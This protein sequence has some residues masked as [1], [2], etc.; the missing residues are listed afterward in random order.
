MYKSVTNN[1]KCNCCNKKLKLTAIKCKC[2]KYFCKLHLAEKNHNCSF[3][4]KGYNQNLLEKTNP[5]VNC[6][7]IKDY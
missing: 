3:D 5:V 7:K 2:D 1:I 6:V 4:Y